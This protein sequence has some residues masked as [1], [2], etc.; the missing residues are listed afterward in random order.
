LQGR[1]IKVDALQDV[2][3]ALLEKLDE[4]DS[5]ANMSCMI[6]RERRR[7]RDGK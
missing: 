6:E 4:L 3:P 1:I 5:G 7:Q 2:I